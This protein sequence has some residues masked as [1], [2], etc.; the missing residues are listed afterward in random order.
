MNLWSTLTNW[1]DTWYNVDNTLSVKLNTFNIINGYYINKLNLSNNINI[2]LKLNSSYTNLKLLQN[3][4]L[5]KYKISKYC[6]LNKINV[7]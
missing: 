5:V 1:I 7:N 2:N 6:Y 4:K 3:N